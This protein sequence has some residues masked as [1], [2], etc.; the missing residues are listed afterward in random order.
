MLESF[1]CTNDAHGAQLLHL[2]LHETKESTVGTRRRGT[3]RRTNW[4]VARVK[5]HYL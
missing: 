3:A 5:F 4:E 1:Y 2:H